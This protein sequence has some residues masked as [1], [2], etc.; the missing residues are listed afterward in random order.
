MRRPTP[1]ARTPLAVAISAT[2]LLLAGCAGLAERTEGRARILG[3]TTCGVVSP[4]LLAGVLE[5]WIDRPAAVGPD[6]PV[7]VEISTGVV[8]PS[9]IDDGCLFALGAGRMIVDGHVRR[10]ANGDFIFVADEIVSA[11]TMTGTTCW[12]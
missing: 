5:R 6:E 10:D 12:P 7:T 4:C 1:T 2:I 9:V 3:A 11:E 8:D